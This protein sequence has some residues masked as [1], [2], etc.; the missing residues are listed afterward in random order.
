MDENRLKHSIAVAR[1]MVEIA[2]SK[3]LSDEDI[4]KCFIIGYNHDVGYEFAK[5]GINHNIIGGEILKNINFKYW[6]E[7]YYHGEINI[8]YKSLY[9]DILNQADM[10]IDKYGND[11]GYD[12]RL[13]DIKNRYEKLLYNLKQLI[14]QFQGK[15]CK[16]IDCNGKE[17]L[18]DI[19]GSL[20]GNKI[21]KICG[22]LDCPSTKKWIEKGYYISNRVFFENEDIAIAA[23]YRPCSICMPNEYKE[24]KNNQKI[25]SAMRFYL[26]A[27]KLKYKIRSGW[28]KNHWNV[29]SE[30]IESIAEHIYGTCILAIS[31]DSEFQLNMDMEKVLKMLTIH[32]IGEVLIGDITPFD[33]ISLEEK[34]KMEHRAMQ[35]V[36]GDLFK[37]DELF[38]L[39]IEFDEHSTKESKFAY[40]CDKMEADIQAKVYQDMGYQHSLDD[41]ENNVVFKS[42]K[43]K[44]MIDNGAQTAFDIWYEWDKSKFDDEPVFI[45]TLSY[46]KKNNTNL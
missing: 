12:K 28:D 45:K 26:L 30:R 20:S 7:I 2:K 32:E 35:N 31:L 29:S 17:Y 4:K 8:E 24:W 40:L 41:Q 43:I 9:L 6:R 13:E 34:T 19:P 36:L 44:E 1:K 3:N 39:L 37:K 11:V 33:K 15:K 38:N 16:L 5:S 14:R 23:G 46:I 42:S 22:R 25:K 21:S 18:S 27:T 10:Q